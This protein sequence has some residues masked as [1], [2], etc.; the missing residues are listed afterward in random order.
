[1]HIK[2]GHIQQTSLSTQ[3]KS[4]E[5][6]RALLYNNQFKNTRHKQLTKMRTRG[7]TALEW[8]VAKQVL[9]CTN[10][11]LAP[12]GSHIKKQVQDIKKVC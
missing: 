10:L 5:E 3:P 6:K 7:V 8:S 12:T 11:T 4:K 1:M 9:G 2:N